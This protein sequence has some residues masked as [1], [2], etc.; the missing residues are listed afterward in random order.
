MLKAQRFFSTDEIFVEI[1]I[2]S[3]IGFGLDLSLKNLSR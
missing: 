2:I 1:L 3:G